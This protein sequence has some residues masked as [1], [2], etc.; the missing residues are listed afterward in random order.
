VIEESLAAAITLFSDPQVEVKVREYASH[1][2]NVAGMVQNPGQKSLQREAIPLYII[3]AEAGVE[4]AATRVVI[5]RA[6]LLK[7]ETYELRDGNTDNVLV[8][9]GNSID[10]TTENGSFRGSGSGYFYISGEIASAGQK[11]LTG[12]LT[13]YQAV[14]ASG[15]AKGSPKKVIIRRKNDKGTLT[16]SEYSFK[17][18]RDGKVPDPLI[19]AGDVIEIGN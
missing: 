11:Q 19:A 3:K 2:I 6:P 14:I 16:M 12:G 13:L 8:Y 15:G 1:K 9:P 5:T 18:V 7:V 17:A 4:P 10:F